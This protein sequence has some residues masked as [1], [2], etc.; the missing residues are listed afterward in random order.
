MSMTATWILLITF[1]NTDLPLDRT[2]E[3]RYDLTEVQ[4]AALAAAIAQ[5]DAIATLCVAP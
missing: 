2:F 5:P 1:L 3:T 4:C